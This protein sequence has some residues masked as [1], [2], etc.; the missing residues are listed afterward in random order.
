MGAAGNH[1]TCH[2]VADMPSP[3]QFD[4][5]VVYCWA[6]CPRLDVAVEA[7]RYWGLT[8]R[9]VAFVWVKTRKDGVPLAGIGVRPTHVKPTTE[10][11]LVG[12]RKRTGRPLPLCNENQAQVI[13]SPRGRHSE[14]PAAVYEA[15]SRLHG[16]EHR[17]VDMF[18]RAER[19]GWEVWG[20]ET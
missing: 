3:M 16:P 12:S 7:L 15:V 11:V 2:G 6:T 19:S 10:L 8:Y 5:D 9:G 13:L 14:K 1:Y 20:D 17:Y 18:A 4:P